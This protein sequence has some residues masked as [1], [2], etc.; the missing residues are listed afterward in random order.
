MPAAVLPIERLAGE[1]IASIYDL[2]ARRRTERPLEQAFLTRSNLATIE[3][4]RSLLAADS[5]APLLPGVPIFLSQEMTDQVVRPAVTRSYMEHACHAGTPVRWRPLEALAWLDRAPDRHESEEV[6]HTDLR[7]AGLDALKRQEEA[8]AL[9]WEAF[10]RWLTPQHLRP[11]LRALS[12]F[13]DV[14][15]EEGAVAHALAP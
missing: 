13:D 6:R 7:I 2:L 4:W 12:G 3:P 8:Q 11:Y 5:P 10:R 1:C 14:E 15:A 9:R